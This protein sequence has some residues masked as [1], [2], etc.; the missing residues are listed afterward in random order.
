MGFRPQTV[1][2]QTIKQLSSHNMPKSMSNE[3]DAMLH[4]Y[5]SVNSVFLGS[6]TF[7]S[8]TITVFFNWSD[9]CNITKVLKYF[10]TSKRYVKVIIA[11]Y[12]LYTSSC[13]TCISKI[14][15]LPQ[16]L[17]VD[18]YVKFAKACALTLCVSTNKKKRQKALIYWP[19]DTTADRNFAIMPTSHENWNAACI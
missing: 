12:S 9:L 2:M 4:F 5:V 6:A 18:F 13:M 11:N 10:K 7:S 14:K 15:Q 3:V 17:P 8:V 16:K 1:K 19:F